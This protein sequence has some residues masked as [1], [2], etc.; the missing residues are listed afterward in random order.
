MKEHDSVTMDFLQAAGLLEADLVW[1]PD[2]E[3]IREPLAKYL[4]VKSGLGI[5]N[6]PYLREVVSR[7]LADEND[8]GI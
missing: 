8:L 2:F 4:R 6:N 5:A 3:S 7:L 1:S